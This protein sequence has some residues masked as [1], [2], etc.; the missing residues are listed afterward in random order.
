MRR[1]D[2]E[3]RGVQLG[4]ALAPVSLGGA[5]RADVERRRDALCLGGATLFGLTLPDFL[6][7]KEQRT[8][9]TLP[10]KAKTDEGE[11]AE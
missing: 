7:A 10:A 11:E 1:I 3:H 8:P 9:G 4:C 6:R 5:A 2:G